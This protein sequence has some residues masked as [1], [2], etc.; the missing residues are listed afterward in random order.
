[1]IAALQFGLTPAAIE[2]EN[3]FGL[4]RLS[5]DSGLDLVAIPDHAHYHIESRLSRLRK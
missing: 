3:I 2:I 5:D 4:V 1:M